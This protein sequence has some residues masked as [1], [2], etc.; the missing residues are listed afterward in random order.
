MVNSIGSSTLILNLTDHFEHFKFMVFK[1]N[2]ALI[3]KIR[4]MSLQLVMPC[5]VTEAVMVD[6]VVVNPT[7]CAI[8]GC[9]H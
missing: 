4:S 2:I 8:S 5:I 3:Y 6:M 1:E 9:H 7:T